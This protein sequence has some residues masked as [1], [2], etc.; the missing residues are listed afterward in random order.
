[1]N[2]FNKIKAYTA[3]HFYHEEVT[4]RHISRNRLMINLSDAKTVGIL[5]EF[6][7]E[8]DYKV[9]TDFIKQLQD[10]GKRVRSIAFFQGKK[11]PHYFVQ[12]LMS[13]L[14]T[15][16]QTNWYGK[17]TADFT[18]DYIQEKFDILI[19]LSLRNNFPL[20]YISGLSNANLKVGLFGETNSHYY[21]VM[22]D[23]IPDT[24]ISEFINQIKHYL[25]LLN[26]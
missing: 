25:S 5:F 24:Q 6:S 20:Q 11:T 4:K 9:V 26:K 2:V 8:D 19:D 12:K 23:P 14:I 21:D 3:C 10:E 13:D 15:P 1:M 17:P 18:E 7:N 16:K 22:L